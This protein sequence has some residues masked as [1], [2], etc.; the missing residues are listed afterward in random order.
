MKRR[1]LNAISVTLIIFAL[2]INSTSVIAN[3]YSKPP[4]TQ[5]PAI[6]EISSPHFIK[7][8]LTGTKA[9]LKWNKIKGALGY[10]VYRSKTLKGPYVFMKKVAKNTTCSTYDANY[11]GTRKTFYYK[12]LAYA[13]SGKKF[14][15]SKLS[16]PIKKILYKRKSVVKGLTYIDG[17]LIANKS[18][19]LPK[20]YNPGVDKAANDA[21]ISMKKAARKSNINLWIVSGFRSYSYQKTLY[22]SYVSYHGKANADRY[23]ARAG[24]SEHQTG[25]AFDLNNASQSFSGTREAKWIEKNCYK[26]GFIIRYPKGK[27]H[28]TG[29]MYE[30]WH[31]RYVG[32]DI[33]KSVYISKKCLEEYLGISSKYKN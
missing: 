31:V 33:A 3:A 27:E 12:V 8:T 11:S 32:K 9:T 14:I 10:K 20:T 18:Y 29:Y 15:Y 5:A 16:N 13:K 30:P 26:Y 28:K 2:V 17:I 6:S 4:E 25:L 19:S 23:S 21:F 24:Y 1:I 7:F 22:N